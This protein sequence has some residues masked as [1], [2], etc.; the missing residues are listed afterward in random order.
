LVLKK[1]YGPVKR[2][3]GNIKQDI[4]TLLDGGNTGL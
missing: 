4:I 2:L 3:S 1:S